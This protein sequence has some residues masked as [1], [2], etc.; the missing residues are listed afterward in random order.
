MTNSNNLSAFTPIKFSLKLVELLYNETIYPLI[1]NTNYEGEI[2][3]EGDRVRVRTAARIT[4]STYIKGMALANQDLN[5]TWEELVVDQMKYFKFEVDDVDALQN[6][7]KAINEYAENAKKDLSEIIDADILDFGRKRVHGANVIGTNYST[8]TIAVTAGTGAVVGTG[9]T[10]TAAM[11][12]GYLTFNGGASY[13]LVTGFT[14]GTAITITDLDGVG[15]SGGTVSGGTAYTIAAAT[16]IALTSANVYQYLVRLGT[17]LSQRLT[18]RVGRFIVIN[19]LMEDILRQAPQFTPAVESAYEAV[20]KQG[21]IGMIAGFTVITSELVAGNNTTGFW[22]F[23][24]TK[25][26]MAFAA[27][28]MKTS[29][30][31]SDSD[32]NSFQT[33]GKGLAVWGREVFNG[34]RGRGAVLR[35]TIA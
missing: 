11:V 20:I 28:I 5:P 34:N 15:Y 26:F 22:F 27:Q 21:K 16:P 6:D 31:P 29:V 10:F 13:F 18:P 9:T 17:V 23:A 14:S 32:P 4:W 1:T 24:G 30:V 7:I 12:G 2:K 19:A 33:T 25:D 35:G 8:G 3:K